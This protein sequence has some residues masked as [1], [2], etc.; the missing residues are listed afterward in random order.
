M[1]EPINHHYIP[2]F[3]LNRWCNSDGKV[4]H[5]YRPHKAVVASPITPKHTGYEP[6]LYSLPGHPPGKEQILE[7]DFMAKAVDDPAAKA[8][9]A[10]VDGDASSMTEEMRIAW[11]RFLMAINLRSPHSLAHVTSSAH[12]I[13]QTN[14]T[15]KP[16]EYLAIKSEDDP[17]NFYEWLQENAPHYMKNVGKLFLPGLIDNEDVGDYLINMKWMKL[18]LSSSQITL[19]VGDGPYIRTHGLKDPSC[20]VAVPL[21]PRL[22]FVATNTKQRQKELLSFDSTKVAKAVNINTVGLADRD[23]Y[24]CDASH[25]RF[26]ENRLCH[27]PRQR[28]SF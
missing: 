16:E 4:I 2:I 22:L 19:L 9:A 14:L 3:Y 7:T 8:L 11:T 12:D 6:R 21:A 15:E 18:P 24:G 25:R 23:V 26:V 28:T 20:I 27:E 13:V 1:S 5:Y 10:F 17:P